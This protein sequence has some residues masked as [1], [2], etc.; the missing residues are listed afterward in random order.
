MDTRTTYLSTTIKVF[1]SAGSS[2]APCRSVKLPEDALT[3]MNDTLEQFEADRHEETLKDQRPTGSTHL[4]GQAIRST[5][6]EN[7]RMSP[8]KLTNQLAV[9]LSKLM[10][11]AVQ[12]TSQTHSIRTFRDLILI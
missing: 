7:Q 8:T 10:L 12:S 4:G 6:V 3:E 9:I 2:D 11:D 1:R 5:R